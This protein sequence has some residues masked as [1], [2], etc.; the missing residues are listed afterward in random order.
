MAGGVRFALCYFKQAPLNNLQ[1]FPINAMSLIVFYSR[2]VPL[3]LESEQNS[4][5]RHL[6]VFN[7]TLASL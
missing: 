3:P 6:S 4:A 5:T 1:W 7:W 2:L